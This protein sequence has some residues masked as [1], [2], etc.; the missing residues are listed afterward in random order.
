MEKVIFDP[1]TYELK[2]P[3]FE[4]I[5]YFNGRLL[6]LEFHQK[7]VD[8]SFSEFFKL[9]TSLNL[10][11]LLANHPIFQGLPVG[12][13]IWRIRVDYNK[14]DTLVKVSPYYKRLIKT[15]QPLDIGEYTYSHKYANRKTLLYFYDQKGLADE[16][17]LVRNGLLTDTS[18]SNIALW[19]GCNWFTPKS[20]LLMG[21]KR[22][23]LLA[24]GRLQEMKLYL[25]DIS[26]FKVISLINSMLDLEDTQIQI[27]SILPIVQNL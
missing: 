23:S 11:K 2:F 19:D 1:T 14:K 25:K 13:E 24:S 18:Y 26:N 12:S 9:K 3:L 10:S 27:P 22:N 5:K 17:L 4:T 20:P 8:R 21:T 16:V 7:R 6:N 15:L